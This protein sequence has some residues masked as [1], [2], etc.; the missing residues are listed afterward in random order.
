MSTGYKPPPVNP[1]TPRRA[2]VVIV[3]FIVGI[4][5]C[6]G[7]YKM[8]MCVFFLFFCFFSILVKL[9]TVVFGCQGVKSRCVSHP[10]PGFNIILKAG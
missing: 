5:C 6:C 2:Y 8:C 4:C 9:H 10:P 1:V 3:V 7:W